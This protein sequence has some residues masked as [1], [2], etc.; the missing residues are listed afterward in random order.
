MRATADNQQVAQSLGVSVK[1]IFALSWCIATVVSA[2][3]GIILGSVRG[4]VDFSLADLGL[5]VFPVVI[6]GGLDSVAGAIIGGVLIGVLENL[7]GRL[8]RPDPRRRGEGGGALRGPRDHPDDSPLRLLRQGRD[9]ARLM[10]CGGFRISYRL[11]ERI[12]DTAPAD[13]RRG[14]PPR[15]RW[16]SCRS[17]PGRTG[18]TCS[19]GSASPSSG[20]W[21]ST[22]SSATPGRSR[23]ATP[24]SWPSAPTPPP[25][26]RPRPGCR[27]TSP[28]RCG[29]LMTSGFGLVFGI[30][31]LRLQGPL[32]GHRH[33]RRALHHHL[34][35]HPLGEHDQRRAGVQRAA[36]HACSGSPLDSDARVFYLI[37]ALVVPAVVLR[38]E[39]LPHPGGPGVHRD[40]RPRRGRR[41]HGREP[42]SLQAARLPD[43]LV[44]R[45]RGRAG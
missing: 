34:R 13:R 25:S 37:F 24:R 4:G 21:G 11:D 19:T 29:A 15:R 38:Q 40:P 22:S 31:S 44:L 41:G 32:P 8:P 2:L 36:G 26:S 5:K 18:S 6:L 28:S 27:S 43:Q 3:G 33:P 30:P 42:L 39:P 17:S 9:R 12:F 1:W 7:A 16:R 23:S 35:H 10:Q 20:R 14:G 45:G